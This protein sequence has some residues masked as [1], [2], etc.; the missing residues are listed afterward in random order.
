MQTVVGTD[1]YSDIAIIKIDADNLPAAT[2]GD[3]GNTKVGDEV[4]AIGNPLGVL[5]SSVSQG[6]HQRA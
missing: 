2:L 3:S 5:T 4:Y 1:T 6:H